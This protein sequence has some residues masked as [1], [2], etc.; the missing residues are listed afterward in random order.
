MFKR[1][2]FN[3]GR[4]AAVRIPKEI[5]DALSIGASTS[6]DCTVR[7]EKIPLSKMWDARK[8]A[9]GTVVVAFGSERD[10]RSLHLW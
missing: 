5:V 3:L 1:K 9:M 7:G 2:T 4:S 8:G 6:V 10:R